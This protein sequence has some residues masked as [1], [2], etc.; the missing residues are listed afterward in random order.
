MYPRKTAKEK[1]RS[2]LQHANTNWRL[3]IFFSRL[4]L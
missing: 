4:V 3:L 1:R 2:I